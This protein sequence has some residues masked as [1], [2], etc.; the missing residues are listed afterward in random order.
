[1]KKA[2][3]EHFKM[4]PDVSRPESYLTAFNLFRFFEDIVSDPEGYRTL[5]PEKILNDLF[6]FRP[7]P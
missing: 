7:C 2:Y 3:T 4:F 6:K 1:M 5:S